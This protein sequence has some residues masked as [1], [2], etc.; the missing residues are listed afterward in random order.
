[1]A[2]TGKVVKIQVNSIFTSLFLFYSLITGLSYNLNS[3][4]LLKIWKHTDIILLWDLMHAFKYAH[5][6]ISYQEKCQKSQL[7]KYYL[8]RWMYHLI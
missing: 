5:I 4:K 7:E 6:F 2:N 8:K 1:M 3:D